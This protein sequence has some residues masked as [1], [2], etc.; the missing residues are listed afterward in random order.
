MTRWMAICTISTA[1]VFWLSIA[2]PVR[3]DDIAPAPLSD[4]SVAAAATSTPGTDGDASGVATVDTGSASAATDQQNEV[5]TTVAS[6]TDTANSTD[7][8][9]TTTNEA[10]IGTQSTTTAETGENVAVGGGGAAVSSGG[11]VA[12]ANV[13]NVANTNIF[14]SNGLILFLNQLFGGAP[15]L[16]TLDLSF[17]FGPGAT[18]SCTFLSCGTSN[19][20]NLIDT[21]TA[22]VT[23]ELMVRAS[24]GNNIASS[25]YG[26]ASVASGDA[27]AAANLLNLVNTNIIDS[28]YLL[29][30]FNNFGNMAGD[31]TLPDA[32]FFSQ[33]LARGAGTMSGDGNTLS[34][35]TDNSVAIGGTT[36][37]D[38]Q[39]GGNLASTTGSASIGSGSAYSNAST[40]TQANS[41]QVGGTSIYLL[42][43][44]W[45]NWSGSVQGLPDGMTWRQ[46][47]NGIELIGANGGS[48]DA[49][50]QG[51]TANTL[52]AS[53]TN[54][55]S[56]TNNVHV[57]S[58]T[59]ENKALSETGDASVQSGNAYAAAN[60]MNLVNTTILGRNWIFAIFNI[61]GDWSGNI[62]FGH[63][64][65]WLGATAQAADP[66]PPGSAV[67]YRFT[68]ANKGD[69]D[70]TG[71]VLH[72]SVDTSKLVFDADS[73]QSA[74]SVTRD[75]V[76]W[77]IGILRKGESRDLMYRATAQR[78]PGGSATPVTLTATISSAQTDENST[79]NTDQ[80]AVAVGDA[81]PLIGGIGPGPWAIEPKVTIEKRASVAA[82][83]AST[84]VDYTV[85]VRNAADAGPAF[86]G[87]LTDEIVAPDGS[88]LYSKNWKLGTIAPGDEI[89]LS[90]TVAFGTSTA[91]GTYGGTAR[92]TA[93]EKNPVDLYAV[94]MP[95]VSAST[96]IEVL[97]RGNAMEVRL[98]EVE[99]EVAAVVQVTQKTTNVA[100]IKKP[101]KLAKKAV[102]RSI[103]KAPAKKAATKPVVR[104]LP[105]P[106]I[107]T[108]AVSDVSL[109]ERVGSWARVLLSAAAA[110]LK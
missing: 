31:I 57:W 54:V 59:G 38:A 53:T 69:A 3:A 46:T 82:T 105:K 95:A 30:S 94:D 65:L 75:G 107:V 49:A 33:L 21:N 88:K 11:A 8:T 45:G 9:S 64:D 81:P 16:R 70:A 40:F 92:V 90:Y 71:V 18:S 84:T 12:T 103:A 100:S 101:I 110:T 23:N 76:S 109:G 5:N 99:A 15:D 58:L 47:P 51:G 43:R 29:V 72:A 34:A 91:L 6:T 102:V 28:N 14:D 56:I 78:V 35:S 98:P 25:T 42:F 2:T 36:T 63:P 1:A 41:T 68:V 27:F 89:R 73:L 50:L 87:K 106:V 86:L 93:R 96:S 66:A 22:T 39:T 60:V 19:T 74:R 4:S 48:G 10:D 55:A 83:V 17:F 79:D 37:A 52:A 97:P 32:D 61:F 67:T 13:I 20:V 62:A 85:V 77:D 80:L 104:D 108:S 26:G 7:L 44:V 24:T